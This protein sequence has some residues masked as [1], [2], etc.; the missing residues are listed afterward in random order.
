[1]SNKK[2]RICVVSFVRVRRY[3]SK[4]SFKATSVTKRERIGRQLV[5]VSRANVRLDVIKFKYQM[6]LFD[7]TS[8]FQSTNRKERNSYIIPIECLEICHLLY[9]DGSNNDNSFRTLEATHLNQHVEFYLT[10]NRVSIY[11]CTIESTISTRMSTPNA[12]RKQFEKQVSI[13]FF[14]KA[15]QDKRETRRLKVPRRNQFRAR[16]SANF[17]TPEFRLIRIY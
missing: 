3:F 15:S 6:Q 7:C 10:T 2:N 4:L 9:L 1:M 8:R 5:R 17:F 11:I 13:A 12:A 14:D 16:L